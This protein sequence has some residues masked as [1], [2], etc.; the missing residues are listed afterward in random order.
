MPVSC[1]KI[2]IITICYN[3]EKDIRPTLESVVNQTYS[4]IEYIIV[5]GASK[6]NTLKIVDEYKDKIAKIISKPDK[7]LYDAIN[8]GIKN[9]TGDIIG[10]IHAGDRLHDQYV[11]EKI[12][13]H[14][15]KNDI[16]AS[17]G[18]SKMVN[19]ANVLV[20]IDKSPEYKR[21]LWKLGWMPAHQSFYAKRELFKKYGYYNL[22]YQIAA[23]YEL[24]LRFLYFN[25]VKVKLLD[26]FTHYFSMGGKSTQGIKNILIQNKE[27]RNAWKDNNQIASFYTMPMKLLQKVPQF[28]KAK[29]LQMSK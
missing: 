26:E 1:V 28:I 12:A 2:S 4:D 27:C 11:I 29:F 7:G 21:Y 3:N 6:D 25:N 10:L 22:Q 8:K 18:H 19:Q 24:M 23:D 9:A 15:E 16:D 13:R 20:R 14:F 17:Y 5:D